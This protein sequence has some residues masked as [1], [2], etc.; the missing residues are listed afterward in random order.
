MKKALIAT[1][2]L[3]LTMVNSVMAAD[4]YVGSF[5]ETQQ[6]KLDAKAAPLV[7]KEKQLR[8]QQKAAQELKAKQAAEKKAQLEAQKKAQE[9]LLAKKKQQVKSVKDSFKQQKNEIKDIFTVK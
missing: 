9:E 2:I 4:T 7:N 3:S 5:L 8:E 1:F 6:K